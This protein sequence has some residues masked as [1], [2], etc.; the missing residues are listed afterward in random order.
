MEII[1]RIASALER[2]SAAL[3]RIAAAAESISATF[4]TFNEKLKDMDVDICDEDD[5]EYIDAEYPDDCECCYESPANFGD[6][7]DLTDLPEEP[8]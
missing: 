1:E 3:E 4:K 2:R 8:E 6:D 7:D 5:D